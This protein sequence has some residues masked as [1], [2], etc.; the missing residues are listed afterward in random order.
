MK[1]WDVGLAKMLH[2]RT[3]PKM[4]GVQIGKVISPLPNI[5]VHINNEEFILE[6]EHLIIAQNIYNHY[7]NVDGTYLLA[8]DQVILI[9]TPDSQVYFLVDKVG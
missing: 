9:P 8:G 6:Q 3:N 2:E 7:R 4:D 5:K 1:S